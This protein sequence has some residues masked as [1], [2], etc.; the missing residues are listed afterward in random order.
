MKSFRQLIAECLPR[1]KEIMPW[2]LEA[3]LESNPQVMLLDIREPYEFDAMHIAGSINVPRGIL[4]SACEYDYE[5]TIPALA[6]ARQQDIVVI[7]RSGFRSVLAVDVMQY[8][9][10]ENLKSLKTGLRGWNDYEQEL[11]DSHGNP[12]EDDAAIDYF[13]PKL[14][15]EQLKK[16]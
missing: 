3:E 2:D 13:T 10:F 4:E 9:G 8:M 11:V 5:E 12:V 14:R 7:C 16:K 1:V 6:E 15:P